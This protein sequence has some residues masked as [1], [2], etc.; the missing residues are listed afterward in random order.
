MKIL[1]FLL[2]V[3]A[4]TNNLY[5]QVPIADFL[6]RHNYKKVKEHMYEA[7]LY[8][9][10]SSSLR[11]NQNKKGIL[12][13]V[14]AKYADTKKIQE[15]VQ[16]ALEF[17][18][19][20]NTL[21]EGVKTAENLYKNLNEILAASSRIN[22]LIEKNWE[23]IHNAEDMQGEIN[24]FIMDAFTMYE[25]FME[26]VIKGTIQLNDGERLSFIYE[27]NED[28]KEKL[29]MLKTIENALKMYNAREVDIITLIK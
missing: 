21:L 26:K 2:L 14:L 16:K 7:Y 19:K 4:T 3:T 11:G 24:D 8:E 6:Q 13:N 25:Q 22:S 27:I 23:E 1:F 10:L 29:V 9:N 28:I 5:S 20:Y 17:Y 15:Y 12:E 18:E